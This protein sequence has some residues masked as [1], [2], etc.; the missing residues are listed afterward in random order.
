MGRNLKIIFL[1]ALSLVLIL[2]VIFAVFMRAERAREDRL[3]WRALAR[4]AEEKTPGMAIAMVDKRLAVHPRDSLLYYYRARLYYEAGSAKEALADAER[5]ISLGYAQEISHLLK[6]LVYGH[7]YGDYARQKELASKA[8]V[9][10]PAYDEAYIV[11][12]EAHYLLGD[13]RACAKDAAAY[14]ALSPGEAEG[15]ETSLLCLERTGDL[16]GAEKAGLKVLELKPA[17]HAAL[18]RLGRLYAATRRH[19][20]AIENFSQAISVSGGR[21]PYYLD[22]A[23]SC[24][25]EKN[26]SC[27]AW[28]YASAMAWTEVSGYASYYYLLGGAMH[29]VGEFEAALEAAGSALKKEPA[30]P[31]FYELRGRILADA[32]KTSAAK[33]D[34]QKMFA[35]SP[36]K[37]AEAESLIE[38]LQIK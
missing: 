26:F 21:A 23:H 31:D 30:N 7:L 6:A 35:L 10:D 29:R 34:F 4:V 24:A 25:E 12:A 9:Y 18:W 36:A 33:K 32:G 14:S 2:T 22:R 37:K 27:A 1:C 3:D 19:Q 20:R 17:S 5:A 15:Y 8:L 38:Q 13:Y 11:R 16:A 28:D